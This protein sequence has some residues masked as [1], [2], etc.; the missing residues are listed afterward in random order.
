MQPMCLMVVEDNPEMRRVIRRMLT[1]VATQIVECADGNE[2]LA[3]YTRAQPDWVLMDIE[4]GEVDGITATRQIKAAFPE[5]RIIIVT[6]HNA[7]ALRTAAYEAGACGYVLKGNLLDVRAMISN[8]TQ[9]DCS[10]R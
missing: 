10:V 9:L 2:A 7:E 6:N 4:L 1:G 8:P 3:V 5:A